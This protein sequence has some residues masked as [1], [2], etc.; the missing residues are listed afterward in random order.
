M[1]LHRCAPAEQVGQLGNVGSDP[2]GLV[3]GEQPGRGAPPRLVLEIDVNS[4]EF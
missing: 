1:P 2:P 3:A 4:G